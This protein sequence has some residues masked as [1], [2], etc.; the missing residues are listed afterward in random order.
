MTAVTI[1]DL[2]V[3]ADLFGGQFGGESWAAWRTLLAGFYGLHLAKKELDTFSSLTGLN[4]PPGQPMDELWR[5]IGRR[6]GK[7]QIAA[8]LAVFEA[9][10]GNYTDRLS[11]GEVATV[12]VLAQDRKQARTVMRY[13]AGLFHSNPMLE[14][15]IYRE[16]GESIELLN[17]TVIE[18]QTASFRAVRGY[19]VACVIA[20]EIAF[21]R[22]DE[23]AN[24]DW[25]IIN[26]L[27][28]AMATLGGNFLTHFLPISYPTPNVDADRRHVTQDMRPQMNLKPIA[29]TFS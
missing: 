12:M 22:S 6:G 20:D 3:D 13:I 19:T 18:V 15:L 16:Q 8:L 27:R 24:P 9:A 5:A 21:W 26:A 25:E 7:S 28:P 11:P 2:M 10:F 1:R 29:M 14:R 17:R 4:E 23:S